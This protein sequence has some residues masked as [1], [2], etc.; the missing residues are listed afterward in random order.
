MDKVLVTGGAGFIGS[1]TVDLL[2][3]KGYSVRILDNCSEPVHF[4][5]KPPAYLN[6]KAEFILGDVTD[7]AAV[8]KA[9]DGVDSVIHLA[10]FQDYLPVFSTF[11]KTNTVGTSLLYEMVV[12]NKLK[13]KK[14]VI[15]SSQAVYGEGRYRCASH[16]VVYPELRSLVQLER[17]DWELSCPGCAKPMAMEPT[18]E[19]TV[20][21][22][23]QYAI[24]KYTQELIGL[25][26][27]KRYGIPTV[28]MR[29]SITQGARQS[30][31]NAY[32]GILR[33]S[34]LRLLSGKQPSIYE[35]GKQMRDYVYV[36]DVARA[37]VLVLENPAADYRCFN[38]GGGTV[39]SVLEYVRRVA[40]VIGREAQ[41]LPAGEFRF[42][43]TRHIVSD[44]S[45]LKRLGWEPRAGLD[46]VIGEYVAW[47]KSELDARDYSAEAETAMK[48]MGVV[49]SVR[50]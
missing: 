26:F 40:A 15:A 41:L 19:S 30:F 47:A 21:P 45:S 46:Q 27:G 38:V 6:P 12:K 31:R 18:D 36:G 49:R 9:L 25:N 33:V 20:K 35:D 11:F 44:V 17:G 39:C 32:S 22:H 1:H 28:C 7:P 14:I 3:S 24:S 50:K 23:N 16:G 29:Y 10:A 34:T 13:I 5:G 37:N 4:K 2:V 8:E 42:G 48:K 43:D